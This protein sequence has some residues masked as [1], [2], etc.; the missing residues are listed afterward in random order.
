M[1]NRKPFVV[2]ALAGILPFRLKANTTQSSERQCASRRFWRGIEPTASALSLTNNA[3]A[4][5][6]LVLLSLVVSSTG[7]S[8]SVQEVSKHAWVSELV[9]AEN[10]ILKLTIKLDAL[11]S[12]AGQLSFP[13]GAAKAMFGDSIDVVDIDGKIDVVESYDSLT[14]QV[15]E[16]GSTSSKR[17]TRDK[18]ILWQPLLGKLQQMKNARFYFVQGQFVDGNRN[19]FE[20]LMG[21][22]GLGQLDTGDWASIHATQSVTWTADP[23]VPDEDVTRW[24]IGNWEQV[25]M[26][27]RRRPALMFRDVFAQAIPEADQKDLLHSL[28]DEY[29]SRLAAGLPL[30]L[31]F[32]DLEPFFATDSTTL[33]PAVSVVDINRDGWDDLYVMTRWQENRL[34]I[35][36]QDGTFVDQ[37]AEYGLNIDRTSC[38]LFADFDNDGDSDVFLGRSY[39]DSLLMVNEGGKFV[40]RTQEKIKQPLPGFVTSISA[41]DYNNDGL[42]DVYLS[43]YVSIGATVQTVTSAA[44]FMPLNEAKRLLKWFKQA[45]PADIWLDRPGPPNRLL[46][47]RGDLRFEPSEAMP[48]VWRTTFQATWAD[49]DQDGDVDLYLCND[50]APD[51]FFRNDG[52][53]GFTNVAQ[54]VGGEAMRGY[55]MGASWGDYDNDGWQDLYVSNMYS[56]AGKRIIGQIPNEM[57]P[58]YML[59]ANGNRLF[60]NA[61]GG[62]LDLVSG[63]GQGQV[64]VTKAGWSWGGQFCDFDN[65]GF[66]DIYVASG[67]YTAPKKISC[68]IDL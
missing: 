55:G 56:K 49:Y 46:V 22:E 17:I 43:T 39:S 63:D 11:N 10:L 41:A 53:R 64:P 21:F 38:A 42:L 23:S 27:V 37:A 31:P 66:L 36:Q 26:K 48:D 51:N 57:D 58:R 59:S 18:L 24:K 62:N 3:I 15:L 54:E 61:G 67:F 6:V 47:N 29:T 52:R 44:N 19:E 2:P 60:K 12:S 16:H 65:D 5:I 33:H 1:K 20:S 9:A 40:D 7:C 14:T 32:A 25:S 68:D 45:T 13:E 4:R 30:N 35:N 34:F 8:N 50:F 28:Q